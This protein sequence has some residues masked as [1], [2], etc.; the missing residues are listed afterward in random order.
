MLASVQQGPYG[1]VVK[2][3]ER[4]SNIIHQAV[5]DKAQRF[6]FVNEH[7]VEAGVV[8]ESITAASEFIEQDRLGTRFNLSESALA[9]INDTMFFNE[10]FVANSRESLSQKNYAVRENNWFVFFQEHSGRIPGPIGVQD[11]DEGGLVMVAKMSIEFAK[12]VGYG[13]RAHNVD[14]ETIYQ[15]TGSQG[16]RPKALDMFDLVLRA[17]NP[18]DSELE[19]PLTFAISY[20]QAYAGAINLMRAYLRYSEE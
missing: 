15:R 18:P 10:A 4:A 6:P 14:L 9:A 1:D 7:F 17:C 2:Y 12:C 8:K 11:L 19:E 5:N 13:L 3:I 16:E 20:F